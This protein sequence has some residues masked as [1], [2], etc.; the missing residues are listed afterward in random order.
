MTSASGSA[1]S[2]LRDAPQLAGSSNETTYAFR[3]GSFNVDIDQ[4]MLTSDLKDKYLSKVEDIITTCVQDAGLH[5]MNM[6]EIGGINASDMKIFQGP[7]APKV[8]IA[9]NYLTAWGFDA[10]TNQIQHAET[11]TYMLSSENC[12]PELVVH[13]FKNGAGFQIVQGNL[14]IKNPQGPPVS[15]TT[16]KRM[17]Q[18]ALRWLEI[19]EPS[20]SATQPVVMV[21]V[22]DCNLSKEQ[23]E[24][25]TQAIQPP[26][27]NWRTVWQVH[28][29]A[30]GKCGDVLFVKGANAYSFDLPDGV[31]NDLH[32][33][34]GIELV[35]NVESEPK[36]TLDIGEAQI[37]PLKKARTLSVMLTE[38]SSEDSSDGT[39]RCFSGRRKI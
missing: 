29:T 32:D 22:G 8:S 3:I 17:V 21:L 30:A 9:S 34:I 6:C 12:K 38:A 27:P 16:R 23:A 5:I 33:A 26:D 36:P 13:L 25:A 1:T 11:E 28:A 19:E 31:K 10:D 7:A 37:R 4:N 15:I 2:G 24:E 35:V 39:R 20:D 14:H 18:E